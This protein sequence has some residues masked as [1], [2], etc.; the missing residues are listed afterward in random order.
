L[1]T[2]YLTSWWQT[3]RINSQREGIV[4]QFRTSRVV[5]LTGGIGQALEWTN[6]PPPP[7]ET[8]TPTFT[9]T[10]TLTYT[11]TDTA[12]VTNTATATDTP[13]TTSTPTVTK[14][15]TITN[16]PTITRTPT[17]TP[18]PTNTRTRVL[19]EPSARRIRVRQPTPLQ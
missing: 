13:T 15:P 17:I 3:L 2:P 8:Y 9:L 1:I 14:T 16:T 7:T 18:T 11:P 4:E 6:T 5:G 12:T 10:P 19:H